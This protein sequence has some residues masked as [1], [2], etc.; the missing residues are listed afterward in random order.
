M[1]A[2]LNAALDRFW[3]IPL[4]YFAIL[5]ILALATP[6]TFAPHYHFWLMP[7]LFGGFIRLTELKPQRKILSAYWFGWLYSTILVD[8]HRLA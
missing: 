6:L 5:T 4:V 1:F 7:L 2:K 3:R 8:T